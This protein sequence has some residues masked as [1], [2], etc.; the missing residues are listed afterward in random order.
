MATALLKKESAV[1]AVT[2]NFV[3]LAATVCLLKLYFNRT[4]RFSDPH[5]IISKIG[6]RARKWLVTIQ[7]MERAMEKEESG[8]RGESARNPGSASA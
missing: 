4:I 8:V 5:F 1:L 7:K 6:G 3:V 2:I